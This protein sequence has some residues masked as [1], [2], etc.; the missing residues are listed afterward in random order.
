MSLKKSNDIIINY[1]CDCKEVRL[2]IIYGSARTTKNDRRK[3]REP[4][5]H[6]VDDTERLKNETQNSSDSVRGGDI[7]KQVCEEY[8]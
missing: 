8:R 6:Y 7:F 5:T 3:W 4:R 1:K 2:T